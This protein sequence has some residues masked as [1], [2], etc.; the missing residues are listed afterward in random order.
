MLRSFIAGVKHVAPLQPAM[1]PMLQPVMQPTLLQPLSNFPMALA[2]RTLKV[3][4]SLR[5][6]CEHCYI[7]R[8]GKIRYVYCKIN[9]RHNARNG[10]KRRKGFLD[11]RPNA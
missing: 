10:P 7:V 8:R 1:H 6:R 4:T 9:P 3:M 2:S 5:K 11:K